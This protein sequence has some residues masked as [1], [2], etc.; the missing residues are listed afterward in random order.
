MSTLYS[1]VDIETTGGRS[2]DN[3]I[4][5]IA[6][7]VFDGEKVVRSFDTLINP[8]KYIPL[9]II[10]FTGITNEMVEHSHKFFEVAKEIIETLE[11]TTFVAHN[12]FFDFNFIKKA[13]RKE[14]SII[15]IQ[16]KYPQSVI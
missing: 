2:R 1:I 9:S 12:A 7:V 3:K 8:E 4:T 13:A 11:G 16:L 10:S 6:I 14:N 5:E 15:L